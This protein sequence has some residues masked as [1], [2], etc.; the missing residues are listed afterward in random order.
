MKCPTG[1]K[2]NL[3]STSSVEKGYQVM[4]LCCHPTV[5]SSEPELFLS[6]RTAATEMGWRLREGRFIGRPKLVSSCGET[7]RPD[8]V[9]DAMVCLQT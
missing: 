7:L 5:K 3:W 1:E 8:T 6:E 9:T 4:G 2:E